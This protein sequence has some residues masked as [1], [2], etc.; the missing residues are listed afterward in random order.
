M[1]DFLFT[2]KDNKLLIAATDLETSITTEIDVMS[3]VDGTVAVPAKILLDTLKALPEQ[4]VTF[5]VNEENLGI[6]ITSAFGKYKLAG[7]NGQDFPKI[8]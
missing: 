3:D 2:I 1:E 5:N 7:E 6:Q 4:P 8:P